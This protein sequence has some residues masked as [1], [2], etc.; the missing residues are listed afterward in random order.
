MG[1]IFGL[2][3]CPKFVVTVCNAS[4]IYIYMCVC[5]CIYI[6]IYIFSP[7]AQAKLT[8]LKDDNYSLAMNELSL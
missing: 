8:W 3:P 1:F 2:R 7:H 6:Y 5:V 4:Y